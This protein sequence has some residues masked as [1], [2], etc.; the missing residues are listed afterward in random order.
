MA[1][2]LRA[3]VREELTNPVKRQAQEIGEEARYNIW[4]SAAYGANHDRIAE[5]KTAYDPTNF[6]RHN[7]SIRLKG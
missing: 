7:Q 4:P 6:F 3:E 1:A 5:I 2:Q